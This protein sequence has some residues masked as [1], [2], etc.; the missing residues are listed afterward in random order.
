M[1]CY[2]KVKGFLNSIFVYLFL[3]LGIISYEFHI[4]D[5]YF[6]VTGVSF[7]CLILFFLSQSKIE[8]TKIKPIWVFFLFFYF[9]SYIISIIY[10]LDYMG[11]LRICVTIFVVYMCIS[12]AK[13]IDDFLR[14]LWFFLIPVLLIAILIQF[15][16]VL[17]NFWEKV[18]LRNASIFFDPN[19]ASAFLGLGALISLCFINSVLKKY[20]FFFLFTVAVFF[21]FSK[22]GILAL[23]FGIFI[24][25]F[26]KYNIYYSFVAISI[27]L[28]SI[29]SVYLNVDLTMFR[30]EQGLNERDNL[31]KFVLNYVLEQQNFFGIGSTDTKFFLQSNNFENSS[32]HNFYFD[33]MLMYGILPFIFNL[34]LA[35]YIICLMYIRN[36]P[37]LPIF[38]FLFV[39]SNSILISF[40]GIGL[41]S[42]LLTLLAT[43]Q[44]A[45]SPLK[46]T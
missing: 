30:V 2:M 27:F 24:Y 40:G 32:T 17:N 15:T 10:N 11:F 42:V 3:V 34:I 23:L 25:Y 12:C 13:Y 8:K 33:S 43:S 21:T 41:L 29:Y 31:W 44:I 14:L 38:V 1:G 7:I 20:L 18:F 9:F 5:Y 28:V 36:S 46:R 45:Y 37:Y 16:P 19:F 26:K 6:I 39:E 4:Y 35:L 22:G